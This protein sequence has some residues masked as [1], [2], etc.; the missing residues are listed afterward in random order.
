MFYVYVLQSETDAGLYIG[1]SATLRQRLFQHAEGLTFSTSFR[2]P[3]KL[4]YYEAYL[5]QADALGR[6]K[7]LKSGAGRQFL[8]KQ[9]KRHFEKHPRLQKQAT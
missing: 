9:L 1:Y 8:D 6:E 2:G 5:E 4:I 7:F 3:W